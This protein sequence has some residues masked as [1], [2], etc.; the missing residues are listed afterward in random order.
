MRGRLLAGA[1]VFLGAMSVGGEAF[2][3]CS[4][5]LNEARRSSDVARVTQLS[6]L[7]NGCVPYIRN[8]ISSRLGELTGQPVPT[9]IPEAA[10]GEKS[11]GSQP[12][13]QRISLAVSQQPFRPLALGQT[14]NGSLSA[15]S[16]V[17]PSTGVPYEF[18]RFTAPTADRLRIS[19]TAVQNS[20]DTY[21]AVGQVDGQEFNEIGYNDDR[22]DGTLNS[23]L[24]FTPA[25]PGDYVIRAR[26]YAQQQYGSYQLLVQPVSVAT[27]TPQALSLGT[28]VS[29]TLGC[30]SSFDR[31]AGGYSYD[32]WTFAAQAGQ[33]IEVSMASYDFD[34]YVAVGRM[35][36]GRFVEVANNDDRGD[37]TLNSALRFV[38]AEAGD[39]VVVARSYAAE[40]WGN[41]DLVV[42]ATPPVVTPTSVGATPSAWMQE[43]DIAADAER[44]YVDFEFEAARGRSYTVRA[45]ATDFVPIID[46]GQPQSDGSLR[47]V[48]FYGVTER[49][50]ETASFSA[51]R[52]GRYVVRVTAPAL[53]GG[54][55]SLLISEVR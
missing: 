49:A 28:P 32:L 45:I 24:C 40:Q 55:F 52:R 38:P 10:G 2:A 19:M 41:Y 18:W 7:A 8:G 47:E 13:G 15:S 53:T 27:A 44:N 9:I 51:E 39:Y 31:N 36:G 12:E 20:F 46:V 43:G 33:R 6:Q 50:S 5:Y 22:G 3:A 14:S 29:G 25:G 21:V 37:R 17:E 34:T 54:H 16:P 42:R 30:E 4:D 35:R 26:S 1:A 48:D 11:D 23:S